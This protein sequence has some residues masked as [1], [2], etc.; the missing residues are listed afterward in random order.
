MVPA[1]QGECVDVLE[2]PA[3][4][5]QGVCVG[6]SLRGGM[7]VRARAVVESVASLLRAGLVGLSLR[8]ATSDDRAVRV[9]ALVES[10]A[11]VCEQG[12]SG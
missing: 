11:A 12:W 5:A 4:Q 3:R 8:G 2:L 7:G 6:R 1:D 9:W 10:G